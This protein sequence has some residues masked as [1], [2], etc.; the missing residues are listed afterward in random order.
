[1]HRPDA[2]HYADMFCWQALRGAFDL[3]DCF[4]DPRA[5]QAVGIVAKLSESGKR[6]SRIGTKIRETRGGQATNANVSM[7][8]RGNQLGH[9]ATGCCFGDK[10]C[11]ARRHSN[12]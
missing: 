2:K 3:A 1:M 9:N 6:R 12:V 7:I 11:D 10:Q 4:V 8:E 5:E